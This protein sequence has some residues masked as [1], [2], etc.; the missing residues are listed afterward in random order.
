MI[1]RIS[2]RIQE[3]MEAFKD[4][5]LRNLLEKRFYFNRVLTPC[6]MDLESL[7]ELEKPVL[8]QPYQII[9]LTEELVESGNLIFPVKS[10]Y[11]KAKVKMRKGLSCYALLKDRLVVGDIW[12]DCPEGP[13]ERASHDDLKWLGIENRPGDVYSFDMFIEAG[14]RGNN[15][16]AP[17]MKGFLYALKDKRFRRSF[18]YYWSDYLPALWMHRILKFKEREQMKVWRFLSLRGGKPIVKEN[19]GS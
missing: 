10:R 2:L 9:Q 6:E 13:D 5:G 19:G 8:D 18:G 4:G 17:F 15:L 3:V 1:D 14:E 7:P 12:C 11:M 16:A